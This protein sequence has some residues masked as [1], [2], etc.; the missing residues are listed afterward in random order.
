[1]RSHS[2]LLRKMC[3]NMP[4]DLVGLLL[5]NIGRGPGSTPS[6]D[7]YVVGQLAVQWALHEVSE[8]A[9]RQLAGFQH[10]CH[11]EH[12]KER[13]PI[14]SAQMI[15]AAAA[16]QFPEPVGSVM[17]TLSMDPDGGFHWPAVKA[18]TLEGVTSGTATLAGILDGLTYLATY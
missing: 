15:L 6:G 14:G 16:G 7:D 2:V 3:L 17:Q 5:G 13:T 4:K 1:M 8:Q 10:L 9:R 11:W 12:L 18:L